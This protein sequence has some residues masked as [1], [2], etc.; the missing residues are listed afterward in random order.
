M[1]N[2]Y[3]QLS[4][5]DPTSFYIQRWADGYMVYYYGLRAFS[6]SITRAKATL[7]R[8]VYVTK[9]YKMRLEESSKSVLNRDDKKLHWTRQITCVDLFIYRA[10]NNKYEVKFVN[11][12]PIQ[13]NPA[14]F[15]VSLPH[16]VFDNRESRL[17]YESRFDATIKEITLN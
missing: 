4:L 5:N 14:K 10:S 7:A 15:A 9:A 1:N 6:Y 11:V 16:Y 12:Y 3:L 8:L 13:N 2:I 17:E